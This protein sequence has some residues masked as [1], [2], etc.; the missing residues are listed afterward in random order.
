MSEW[1]PPDPDS[2]LSQD[3]SCKGLLETAWLWILAWGIPPSA[4]L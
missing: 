2:Q 1:S 3:Q 4:Q